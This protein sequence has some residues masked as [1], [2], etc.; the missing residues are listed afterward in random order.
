MSR[1]SLR[2]LSL[3]GSAS[4]LTTTIGFLGAAQADTTAI[5]GTIDPA[6][7]YDAAALPGPPGPDL[8]FDDLSTAG[9]AVP[10][11]ANILSDQIIGGVATGTATT[12]GSSVLSGSFVFNNATFSEAGNDIFSQSRGNNV[13]SL[14]GTAGVAGNSDGAIILNVQQAERD[15]LGGGLS[16]SASTEF[17]FVATVLLGN[18]QNVTASVTENSITARASFNT[19]FA[20]IE[21]TVP[22]GLNGGSAGSYAA[23]YVAP[24]SNQYPTTLTQ[25]ANFNV[26]SVQ[27]LSGFSNG[28]DPGEGTANVDDALIDLT[29]IYGVVTTTVS[30]AYEVSAN[31]I[32]ASTQGNGADN[33]IFL[34]SGDSQFF[35]GTAFVSSTQLSLDSVN[36]LGNL[37]GISATNTD[38]II[39]VNFVE[40]FGADIAGNGATISL[41]SD[42]DSAGNIISSS[43]TINSSRNELAFDSSLDLAGGDSPSSLFLSIGPTVP[44]KL[45]TA[46]GDFGVA[47]QQTVLPILPLQ[48]PQAAS[49]ETDDAAIVLFI[50]DV[51]ASSTLTVNGNAITSTASGNLNTNIVANNGGTLGTDSSVI[52]GTFLSANRQLLFRPDI[53]ART[54]DSEIQ[55]LVGTLEILPT[56]AFGGLVGSTLEVSGNEFAA[57]ATGSGASALIDL[58]GLSIDTGTDGA[59]ILS[60]HEAGGSALYTG[61]AVDGGVAIGNNQ[62]N[63]QNGAT[64]GNISSLVDNNLV[65]AFVNFDLDTLDVS[66]EAVT[67]ST[68]SLDGN[69]FVAS[70]TMNGFDG[71]VSLDADTL[72]TGDVAVGGT[73]A[74]GGAGNPANP[75]APGPFTVAA[76]LTDN[77]VNAGLGISGTATSLTVAIDNSRFL[78]LANGNDSALGIEVTA[79]SI[80]GET[81]LGSGLANALILPGAVAGQEPAGTAILAGAAFLVTS[82]QL[83]TQAT[84]SADASGNS[85]NLGLIPD[86]VVDDAILTDSSLS[87]S[88]NRF[89]AQVLGN[90]TGNAVALVA[91]NSL[92]LVPDSN[93][94]IAGIVSSQSLVTGTSGDSSLT[95][96]AADNSVNIFGMQTQNTASL[97][98][99][100]LNANSN[101]IQS[102]AFANSASNV[103]T[104]DAASINATDIGGVGLLAADMGGVDITLSVT[105]AGFYVINRQR[106]EALSPETALFGGAAVTAT[107]TNNAIDLTLNGGNDGASD[108]TIHTD[109]NQ[110]LA[111]AAANVA[112]NAILT[113]SGVSGDAASGVLNLQGNSGAVTATN[114]DSLINVVLQANGSDPD[115]ATHNDVT[116]NVDSNVIGSSATGSSAT[117]VIQATAGT[118]LNGTNDLLGFGP[119]NGASIGAAPPLLTYFA[120]VD[121]SSGDIDANAGA[122]AVGNL[123]ILNT[124]RSYGAGDEGLTISSETTDASVGLTVAR[125]DVLSTNATLSLSSN[126]IQ[127]QAVANVAANAISTTTGTGGP[128]SAT[129]L[130]NQAA[131]DTTVVASVLNADLAVSV[132][133]SMTNSTITVSDNSI[134]A[135]ADVNSASNSISGTAGVGGLP[136]GTIVNYQVSTGSSASSTVSGASISQTSGNIAG[137]PGGL[138]SSTVVASGN[139]IGTSST[140]NNATNRIASPGQSFTRTSSF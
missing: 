14:I 117:N 89:I 136:S 118:T 66:T 131:A 88:G 106:N 27:A 107:T 60:F 4:L 102:L 132:A 110:L 64:A 68:V 63:F 91:T 21:T 72:M 79:D 73:Q 3:L 93:G 5:V 108:T 119:V 97:A 45:F 99:V 80:V 123:S 9:A 34:R 32:G 87:A 52:E 57:T 12:G 100:T 133:G 116:L 109:L 19:A 42:G 50:P 20:T 55:A 16:L 67:N 13:S 127:S 124:Q 18:G 49:A 22:N 8:I 138:T 125:D 11:L 85:V 39:S 48:L 46:T 84:L 139:Q 134:V 115:D 129:V 112:T 37:S 105:S 94:A 135:S 38:S 53:D 95:A 28:S 92:D 36:P 31:A 126:S 47:N 6:A 35:D 59:L 128:A 130:N 43:A 41:G 7:T 62:V 40:A 69:R 24:P 76:T 33:S 82:D 113:S 30:G 120:T 122:S 104:A 29:R 26:A 86:D 23:T 15:P 96:T 77:A 25:T 137:T 114:S 74:A 90:Q 1:K 71:L 121:T 2:R 65:E 51:D 70:S 61:V 101:V 17:N 103:I 58:A 10:P 78:A 98:D 81:L 54:T 75:A 83:L 44:Q 56:P 111:T 140:I